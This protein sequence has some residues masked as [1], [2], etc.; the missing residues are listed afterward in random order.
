MSLLKPKWFLS[1]MKEWIK[2]ISKLKLYKSYFL[3]ITFA[4]IQN[5]KMAESKL[6]YVDALKAPRAILPKPSPVEEIEDLIL[7]PAFKIYA[8]YISLSIFD[9]NNIATAFYSAADN[10]YKISFNNGTKS[11]KVDPDFKVKNLICILCRCS[12]KIIHS[13]DVDIGY[14][15]EVASEFLEKNIGD[16]KGSY[17]VNI[18]DL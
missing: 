2:F 4:D 10:K 18:Q 1:Y 3:K 17:D 12:L 6:S 7:N 14:S 11:I 15:G 8:G 13:S 16:I 9:S 5:I